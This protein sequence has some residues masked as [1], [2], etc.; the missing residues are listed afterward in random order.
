MLEP[1]APVAASHVTPPVQS[2]FVAH[3][4]RQVPLAGSHAN[5]AQSAT[6]P[7]TATELAPSAEHVDGPAGSTQLPPLQRN[8]ATQSV[9]AAQVVLQAE[10]LAHARFPGHAAVAHAPALHVP[11]VP[12]LQPPPQR[13]S[14]P[15]ITQPL[16]FTPSQ[17]PAHAAMPEHCGC[18]GLGLDFAA[19]TVHFPALPGSAQASHCPVQA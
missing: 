18:P 12:A 19:T 4:A 1:Q 9:S 11:S 10:A 2:S 3:V 16:R 6:V 8:P 7:S 14:F 5:G 15:G 17:I 13:V